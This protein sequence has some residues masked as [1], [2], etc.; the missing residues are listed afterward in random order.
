MSDTD[1]LV[2]QAARID[3]TVTDL[4]GVAVDPADIRLLSLD[5]SGT[6][7][8]IPADQIVKDAVGAYHCD[9]TLT[10]AGRWYYR[11]ETGSPATSAA[12]G[13]INVQPSR[14]KK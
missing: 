13:M 9:L 3:A 10:K 6:T 7:T 12:E 5:P 8:E 1:Y 14:F 2:G 4:S 11:W